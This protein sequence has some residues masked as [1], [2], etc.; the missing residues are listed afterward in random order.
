LKSHRSLNL[1]LIG[2]ALQLA[3]TAGGIAVGIEYDTPQ[4]FY[5]ISLVFAFSCGAIFVYSYRP[6]SW[7]AKVVGLVTHALF[8]LFALFGLTL[9][10]FCKLKTCS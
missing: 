3:L 1:I 7:A 9:F 6:R 5:V 8:S 4:W 10:H 2:L